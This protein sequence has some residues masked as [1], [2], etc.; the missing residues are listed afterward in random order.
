MMPSKPYQQILIQE[1][2]EPLV[3]I[4]IGSFVIELPHPYQKLG[5]P[6]GEKSPYCLRQGVISSLTQAQVYLQ[7][8]RS[9]W[10]IQIF[11]AYR[12]IAV[13]QFM[14]DYTF[15]QQLQ[16]QN[17]TPEALT[18]EQCQTILE[19]VYEFWAVPSLDLATPPPHSTGGAVDVTLVDATGRVVEMGSP[20]DELSL[21]SYP[22]Y[23]SET[24]NPQETAYHTARELLRS[25]MRLAG[26][27]Q[28][29]QE[30][31]HFSQGDQLWAWLENQQQ[32]HRETAPT[33]TDV[34]WLPNAAALS[35]DQEPK[36]C[37]RYGA[38]E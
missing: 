3:L 23:F 25:V 31:W 34:P 11:D 4:P 10:R 20:I 16:S 9:E 22:D 29:P 21:R 2:G 27:Q 32:G 1:C 24:T 33:E 37:A 35:P 7:E 17:L 26:F 14:V 30:W 36:V 38:V 13:Q 19:Q 8:Q 15:N 18:N 5:A 28:H 6:Y 12:P